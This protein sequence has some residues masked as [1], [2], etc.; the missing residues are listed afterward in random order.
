MMRAACCVLGG[1]T[2]VYQYQ[3]HMFQHPLEYRHL[4]Y[5][6]WQEGSETNEA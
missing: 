4:P 2:V 6:K 1:G 5:S 3:A